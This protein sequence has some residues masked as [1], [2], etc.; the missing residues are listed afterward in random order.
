MG[1]RGVRVGVGSG[2]MWDLG[3]EGT[4]FHVEGLVIHFGCI[5]L[6]RSKGRTGNGAD[7]GKV[8]IIDL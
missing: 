3:A 2:I 8:E 7:S 4:G 1:G 5:I 6:S